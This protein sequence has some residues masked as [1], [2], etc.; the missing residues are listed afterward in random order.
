VP[1]DFEFDGD[2]LDLEDMDITA[3]EL[4]R[5]I[6]DC[7]DGFTYEML[8]TDDEDFVFKCNK[9]GRTAAIHERPFPHKLNCEMRKRFGR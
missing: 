5:R 8:K 4:K 3:E 6:Q 2:D 7:N 1:E 9:C